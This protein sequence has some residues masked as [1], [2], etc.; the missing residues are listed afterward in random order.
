MNSDLAEGE[1]DTQGERDLAQDGASSDQEDMEEPL[2]I[3]QSGGN[4]F[5]LQNISEFNMSASIDND[6][7]FRNSASNKYKRNKD[8]AQR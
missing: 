8:S 1:G 2:I 6:T 5:H 7:S 3:D 4:P